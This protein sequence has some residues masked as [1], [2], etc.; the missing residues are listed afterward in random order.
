MPGDAVLEAPGILARPV[1]VDALFDHERAREVALA[2]LLAKHGHG[3]LDALH[4]NAR[5]EGEAIGR[6]EGLRRAVQTLCGGF[7]IDVDEPR[8]AQISAADEAALDALLA[9]LATHRAWPG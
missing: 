1:P 9:H 5:A 4:A 6:A 7:G 8:R 3:S 2:N